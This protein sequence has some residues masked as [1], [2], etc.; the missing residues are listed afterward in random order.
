MPLRRGLDLAG[1]FIC[2]CIFNWQNVLNTHHASAHGGSFDL[3]VK[4]LDYIMLK[5]V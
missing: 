4:T 5:L 1:I 2:V 3:I